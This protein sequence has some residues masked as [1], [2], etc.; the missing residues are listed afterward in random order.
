MR[1]SLKILPAVAAAALLACAAGC[2]SSGC[3]DNRSA[4]PRAEFYSSATKKS[5]SFNGLEIHGVH[6]PNDSLLIRKIQI[7]SNF[8]LPMRSSYS[9]TEWCIHYVR[10]GISDIAYN[11]TIL[12]EYDSQPYFASEDCGAM[13]NYR[14][15]RMHNTTHVLDSV[16]ILDSLITNV[17]IVRIRIY[18]P[19]LPPME[20][21]SPST[22]DNPDNPDEGEADSGESEPN[23]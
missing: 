23:E 8:Y 21:D 4:I 6:A 11:D 10:Q 5:Q 17:D 15:T 13:F 12:F 18:M 16:E 20:T 14:I 19:E 9:S 1:S 7:V 2:S 3:L 22:P